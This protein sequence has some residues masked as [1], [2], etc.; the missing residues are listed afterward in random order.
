[1]AS[2]TKVNDSVSSG[3]DGRELL[4]SGGNSG[5][6]FSICNKMILKGKVNA[7]AKEEVLISRPFMCI[8]EDEPDTHEC[9]HL[10]SYH[11]KHFHSS[12]PLASFISSKHDCPCVPASLGRIK[13]PLLLYLY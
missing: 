2:T 12:M 10:P 11:R 5:C 6:I 8:K 13:R 9:L 7:E 1:M 3:C 4:P